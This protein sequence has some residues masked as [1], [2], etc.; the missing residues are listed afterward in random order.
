M[1]LT[2]LETAREALAVR[3]REAAEYGWTETEVHVEHLRAALAA[4]D[5]LAFV[6]AELESALVEAEDRGIA[7]GAREAL[8]TVTPSLLG[9]PVGWRESAQS[10]AGRAKGTLRLARVPADAGLGARVEGQ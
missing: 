8:A 1:P 9:C 5:R 2:H 6:V 3:D 7:A 10:I 4:H